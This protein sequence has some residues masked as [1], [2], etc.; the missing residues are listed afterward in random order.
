MCRKTHALEPN[1]GADLQDMAVA[2]I[3]EGTDT[4]YL[5]EKIGQGRFASVWKAVLADG[6]LVAVKVF[7]SH[8]KDSWQREIDIFQT[9]D[10][11]H[12]NI[13]LFLSSEI[14]RNEHWLLT[15]YHPQ[16]SLYDLLHRNTVTL[17]QFCIMAETAALGLAHLHSERIVGGVTRKP[18]IAHRDLKSKNILIRH[19]GQ[20]V[21]SDF[22][23]AWRFQ[24][25]QSPS[26]AQGQVGTSRYMAPEVLEG[27]INFQRESFLRIDIYALA[28]IMWE[29]A[30]R[31]AILGATPP[32]YCPPFDDVV[33]QNPSLEE[34]R[35]VVVQQQLRPQI[36]KGF[37]NSDMD[38]VPQTIE[39]SWDQDSEARLS[40][41]CIAERI[42]AFR[43]SKPGAATFKDSGYLD[44]SG[45]NHE[46]LDSTASP[47]TP[48]PTTPSICSSFTMS[49]LEV[50]P[51]LSTPQPQGPDDAK[52]NNQ[53]L[54]LSQL[55]L[56]QRQN[57]T[58]VYSTETTV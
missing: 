52:F 12:K 17:A 58:L 38:T 40:A 3:L 35:E 39:E 32:E 57:S 19:D 43:Q 45:P 24:P 36:P 23:L 14:H 44:S 26:E 34:M 46:S 51:P 4:T 18:A 54:S 49:P 29:I 2:P 20:C 5:Q 50:K 28:L 42:R 31:T 55:Q 21:I 25:G 48:Q 30:S 16:G 47:Y 22:G 1:I 7:Q 37:I 10:L 9:A 6:R 13:L 53:R 15:E 33:S 11:Q 56:Q 27:A 8:G 41:Q